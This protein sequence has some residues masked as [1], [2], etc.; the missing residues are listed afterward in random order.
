M[1][2][3][4]GAF[5]ADVT[6][7]DCSTQPR[8]RSVVKTWRL[9]NTGS[10]AWT[11]RFLQRVGSGEGS[12]ECRAPDRVAIPDTLPGATVDVSV[13]VATPHQQA[14]CFGR[15]MQTDSHGN[16]T[17]PDQRPYYYSFFVR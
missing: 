8:G 17:F 4:K 7:P 11:G 9:K 6:V 14:T 12:R 1:E 15:W 2:G 10:V 3:D 16:F 13:T 5:V